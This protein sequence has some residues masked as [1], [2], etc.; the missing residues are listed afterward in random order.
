MEEKNTSISRK[1]V[2]NANT[3]FSCNL[4]SKWLVFN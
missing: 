4:T 3:N 1:E 2:S